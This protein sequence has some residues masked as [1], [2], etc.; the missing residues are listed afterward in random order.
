MKDWD[1]EW[2]ALCAAEQQAFEVHMAA[3]ERLTRQRLHG[4]ESDLALSRE[5]AEAERAWKTA[6]A[7][8]DHFL[9]AWRRAA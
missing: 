8:C 1:T 6:E 7:A 5:A 3:Q 4:P 9:T 2:P